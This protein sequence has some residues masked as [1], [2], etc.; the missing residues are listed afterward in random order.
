MRLHLLPRQPFRIPFP[1][2]SRQLHVG[3]I[4]RPSE[5][6][7]VNARKALI[8]VFALAALTLTSCGTV[9]RAGKDIMLGVGTPVL[10]IYGGATDGLTTSQN[11]REGMGSG[12]AVQVAAFPFTFFYHAIEH[13]IYGLTHLVDLPFCVFYG[14]AELHPAGPE[15]MPLDIYQGT[16]FDSAAGNGSSTDAESGE[17][18]PSS[19]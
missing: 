5:V 9:K 3:G 14:P 7:T 8:S 13:G 4:G 11:V 10:M 6:S 12:A 16:W 15:V 19:N 2:T 1:I 18:V 17:M